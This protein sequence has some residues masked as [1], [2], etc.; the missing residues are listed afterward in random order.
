MYEM[1]AGFSIMQCVSRR[2]TYSVDDAKT[3]RS[4]YSVEKGV[5]RRKGGLRLVGDWS[6][7]TTSDAAQPHRVRSLCRNIS[8]NTTSALVEEGFRSL[9]R[10]KVFQGSQRSLS[11]RSWT[12]G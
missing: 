9:M 11:P 2:S 7:S 1:C 8:S 4:G 12:L 10:I 5:R 6:H 3:P